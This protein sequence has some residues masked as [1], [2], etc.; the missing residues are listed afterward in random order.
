MSHLEL[1]TVY[2]AEDG[3]PT[4]FPNGADTVV[5]IQPYEA[6]FPVHHYVTCGAFGLFKSLLPE[7]KKAEQKL[8]VGEIRVGSQEKGKGKEDD[9]SLRVDLPFLPAEH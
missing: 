1:L 3:K 6:V 9:L 8:K 4:P 5:Y 7:L 2:H